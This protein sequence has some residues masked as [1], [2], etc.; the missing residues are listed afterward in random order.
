MLVIWNEILLSYL[1]KKR[2]GNSVLVHVMKPYRGVEVQL[3]L[4]LNLG[5]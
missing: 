4:I 3:V 2:G 1:K 5:W